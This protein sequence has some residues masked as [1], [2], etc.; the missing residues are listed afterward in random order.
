M[1]ALENISASGNDNGTSFTNLNSS[2]ETG[3][4]HG[5]WNE[6]D[7]VNTGFLQLLTGNIPISS[8]IIRYEGKRL[9]HA[10]VVYYNR[11]ALPRPHQHSR[12]LVYLFD[13]I[14]DPADLAS[15]V[16]LYKIIHPLKQMGRTILITSTD[17]NALK[18]PTDFFHIFSKGAF[19]A[20]LHARQYHLL[21]DV[22][23]HL[24]R[25]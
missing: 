20:R 8:G 10:D 1:I 13:N 22:F 4:I 21:D 14:F 16:R 5:I 6:A 15:M 11:A 17:Y 24:Q 2:F 9:D 23:R 3:R 12:K 18:A 25:S 7:S 19:Q